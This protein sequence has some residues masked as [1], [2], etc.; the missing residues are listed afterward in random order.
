MRSLCAVL[1][2]ASILVASHAQD[3]M[4]NTVGS[5][6]T[7]NFNEVSE[8]E[9]AAPANFDMNAA[10]LTANMLELEE[11]KGDKKLDVAEAHRGALLRTCMNHCGGLC[12][13][14]CSKFKVLKVCNGCLRGCFK[15]CDVKEEVIAN[16]SDTFPTSHIMPLGR[17]PQS[18]SH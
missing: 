13:Q 6:K 3:I 7:D 15:R 16:Q 11:A 10:T 14:I 2:F 17:A 5:P 9:E 4:M 1:L 12:Q 8:P 18:M